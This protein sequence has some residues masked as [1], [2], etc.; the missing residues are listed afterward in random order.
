ME[1]AQSETLRALYPEHADRITTLDP[2]GHDVADPFGG[3]GK[4]Y[5]TCFKTI[6]S[7]VKIR[8]NQLL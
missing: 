4:D 3:T 7:L 6:E 1:K 5:R 2:S 8:L